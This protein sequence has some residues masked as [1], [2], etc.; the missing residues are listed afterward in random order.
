VA[1]VVTETETVTVSAVEMAMIEANAKKMAA[2]MAKLKADNAALTAAPAVDTAELAA[3]L[4]AAQAENEKLKL[5]Q[6]V[7]Q[8]RNLSIRVSEKGAVSLYGMGKFPVSLYVEQWE[9]IFANA[10]DIK[11]FIADNGKVLKRKGTTQ[12]A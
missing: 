6:A 2:E 12:T 5:Q 11:T 4:A 9:C 10:E 7:K 3:K 1:P 8:T